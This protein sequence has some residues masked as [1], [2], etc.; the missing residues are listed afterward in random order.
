[1]EEVLDLEDLTVLEDKDVDS[2]INNVADSTKMKEALKEMK[3]FQYY[4]SATASLLQE[5]GTHASSRYISLW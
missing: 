4:Y 3:E 1:M 5:L 2:L